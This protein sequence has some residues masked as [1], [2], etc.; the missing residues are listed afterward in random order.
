M[1]TG[2]RALRR[3]DSTRRCS[4]GALAA[5]LL[6]ALLTLGQ[7]RAHQ[8]SVVYSDLRVDGRALRCTFQVASA[9]L[10]EALALARDR[11][12]T[13]SE[14]QAGAAR[15]AA[16]LAARVH[17]ENNGNPCPAALEGASHRLLE[18]PGTAGGFFFVQELSFQCARSIADLTVTYDLFFDIDPRHQGLV[19]VRSGDRE[20][21]QVFRDR[22]RKLTLSRPLG[23][24]DHARDYLELGVEHIFTGYDHLAFLFG[25]LLLAATLGA[26]TPS[27]ARPPGGSIPAAPGGPR[28]GRLRLLPEGVVHVL[29]VVTAFTIAHSV[30]LVLAALQVV[31]LPG[32][33]VETAIAVSIGYVAAENLLRPQVVAARHRFA[34]TFAFGL[35]HG[36]GFASVLR[37]IGLPER[38]L[39]LSLFSFNVGVELGQLLVVAL[40]FPALRAL[41]LASPADGA[42]GALPLRHLMGLA[43][44]SA[45]AVLL[46]SRFSIPWPY[47]VTTM[48]AV[49]AL[50]VPLAPRLGYDRCVRV[51]GS[52][53]LLAFSLLWTVERLAGITLLGGALG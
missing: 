49:P 48:V 4:A 36:F 19:H 15:I 22:S 33:L 37:E 26:G 13:A 38:G 11:P 47:M 25:L 40:T 32:R 20:S 12:A 3:R 7:A 1:I 24:W 14:A 5:V 34:L 10:Y 44:L 6:L 46:F 16:Y 17:V 30:T 28:R 39:L 29:G 8:S 23:P 18:R 9:D 45:G 50:L 35:V 43:A 53:V 51:A 21:E 41:A 31:S 52:L 42:R 2:R 27:G